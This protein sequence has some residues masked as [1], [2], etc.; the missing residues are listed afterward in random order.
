MKTRLALAGVLFTLAGPALSQSDAQ[1][2]ATARWTEGITEV[3]GLSALTPFSDIP[4]DDQD[5][6]GIC[7]FKQKVLRNALQATTD[8]LAHLNGQ[9][10]ESRDDPARMK[11][12]H[13][14]GQLHSYQGT[15]QQA[16]ASFTAAH[17]IATEQGLHS[18]ALSLEEKLGIAHLRRGENENCVQNHHAKSC[19]FPIDREAR[20]QLPSGS[21]SAIHHF[22][23]FLEKDPGNLEVRWLLNIASMTLGKYPADIPE[24][25]LI[26]PSAFSSDENIGSF[27][28]I[29]PAVGL[30]TWN[31]AGG[32]ILE[33]FDRDGLL[34]VVVSTQDSCECLRYFRN[35]G[36]GT[37]S[38]RTA[39]AGLSSQLGGLN[40]S[41]AD[42][43]NDGWSDILVIRGG[44]EFPMRR[45]LLRNQGDGTFRD[46]T[47][48]SG[49]AVPAAAS[50]T[51]AWA[52]FDNDGYV[53]L[54]S[55]NEGS[56]SQLF[57]NQGDGTFRDIA[58]TAGVAKVAFTKGA[59]W[60]DYDLDGLTDLYV[61]NYGSDN[62]LYHNNGDGTFTDVAGKLGVE[63]PK[64][65]FPTWWM[66]YDNDGLP[67]LF[68]SGFVQ[69]VSEVAKGYL[70]ERLQ[71]ET[72]KVY[73]NTGSGFE[74]VTEKAGMARNALTMGCN[75]GDIDNDGFL[76]IYLGTGA[77]SYAALV[78]NLLF[79][80]QAGKRFVDITTSSGAGHLQKGHGIAFGDLNNDG[81]PE[82]FLHTGGAVP[83]DSYANAVFKAPGNA[84]GWME[85]RMV[86]KKSNRSAIG[87]RIKITLP[88]GRHIY[89]YVTSGS[90][91]GASAFQQHIG[92]AAAPRVEALEIWW[93][94]SD[95]R[96]TFRNL[97]RNQA[98][99]IQ[100]F[101]K[102]FKPLPRK[103]F[104]WPLGN[105][106]HN[107]GKK[108]R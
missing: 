76:D 22:L 64:Y 5:L 94:A 103:S 99:E 3:A 32:T 69:S 9:P 96:Q 62:F 58:A 106:P 57:R 87:A 15:M 70:G 31:M 81:Q 85:I 95:S 11:L 44:W 74:D 101:D 71:T 23:K 86:G 89:R 60:A 29:A 21:Q 25:Y 63:R 8:Y 51:A 36:N 61:S 2:Q 47:R 104:A 88:G 27:T 54:F 26:P 4:Y 10:Q 90:S 97:A 45:S 100:E 17:K 59:S 38:D 41:H 42:Y 78:P 14:L 33:D 46:V 92:L 53:D 18:F 72:F 16:I 13:Q 107:H 105:S 80:N 75:F 73:R 49:L 28:D 1:G 82:I 98:I 39:A 19:I 93:P 102:T 56:P 7:A 67:D 84:N 37:F 40:L 43:D 35:N 55:G 65:S 79:R 91:F 48:E 30:D 108:K 20:H 52:D 66:D 12:H 68:V 34:D 6:A 83:G 24:R 77:P 50:Q